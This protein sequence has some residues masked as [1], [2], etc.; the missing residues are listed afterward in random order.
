MGWKRSAASRR[1]S[2]KL[3][4]CVLASWAMEALEPRCLLAA[5]LVQ[6]INT[7]WTI[8]APSSL[9]EVGGQVYFTV[10]GRLWR[11]DGTESGTIQVSPSALSPSRLTAVGDRLFF[12]SGGRLW[13]SDGTAEGTIQL[14]PTVS[15]ISMLTN[16]NGTLFF[17]GSDEAG[18]EL[19]KSDGTV[20]G[21]V[22]VR[23]IV[24][25][26]GGSTPQ[27]L[28]NVNGILYFRAADAAGDWELWRSDGT[29]AGTF[30]VRD[31]N[32]G[33]SSFPSALA[34]VGNALFFVATD[35]V[36]GYELWKSDGTAGGTVLV[37]DINPGPAGSSAA[38]LTAVGNT[39]YFVATDGASG[40]E[41]WK[42][43]GTAGGTQMVK[44]IGFGAASAQVSQ[45]INVG[46]TLFFTASTAATGIELWTSDGTEA[47]TR[48]VKDINPGA[49]TSS[50][51]SLT[52]VGTTLFFTANDGTAGRELW[53]SDGTAGGT[54]LVK[55]LSP[56]AGSSSPDAL[57]AA[58]GMLLFVANDGSGSRLYRSDGTAGGTVAVRQFTGGAAGSSPASLTEV[59]GTLFFTA[60]DGIHGRELWKTDGT[61]TAMV[62]DIAAGAASSYPSYLTDVNGRLFF[63]AGGRLWTSDGTAAGTVEV[64]AGP[65][66]M[67]DP[68]AVGGTLYFRGRDSRG[69]ELWKSDGTAGGTGLVRDIVAGGDGIGPQHLVSAGGKLYFAADDGVHGWELWTSDGT[70]AGTVM[71]KDIVPGGGSSGPFELTAVGRALFFRATDGVNGY[72]LWKSDG[73]AA[74]TVLV[75]DIRPGAAGSELR[76]LTAAGGLL[77]F[78]ADDGV[79]GQELWKSDG[80]EAGTVLVK[81]IIAGAV[82][83]CPY[84]L[85]DIDGTV[86]FGA[87]DGVHGSELWKSDGTAGGTVLVKDIRPGAGGSGASMMRNINGKLLFMGTTNPWGGQV[88]QSDGTAAGTFMLTWMYPA[89]PTPAGG[90][91]Y[92]SASDGLIGQ[93]LW[94]V[95]PVAG[96]GAAQ[97]P[98]SPSP[99]PPP[100][101][102]APPEAA[103]PN[104]D[105]RVF[106]GTSMRDKPDTRGYGAERITGSG[107]AMW[108][109]VY[110]YPETYTPNESAV[111]AY[112]V[113]MADTGQP[114]Y[115]DIEHWPVD[116]RWASEGA[117]AAAVEKLVRIVNWMH[118][119]RPELQV[120]Y[121]DLVPLYS[122]NFGDPKW[123]AANSRLAPLA[124]AVDVISPSLYTNYADPAGWLTWARSALGE[125]AKYNKPVRPFLWMRYSAGGAWQTVTGDY[126]RTML[127]TVRDLGDDAIIWDYGSIWDEQAQWWAVT[128]DFLA[129]PDRTVP[130]APD[131]LVAIAA[132][133]TRVE[134]AWRD[135]SN[136]ESEF[137]IER[138]ADGQSFAPLATVSAGV[139]AY[140]D[141]TATA[142]QTYHY[143]ILSANRA[144]ASAW[145]AVAMATTPTSPTSSI[146]G[147]WRLDEIAGL[148]AADSSGRGHDGLLAG[149]GAWTGGTLGN[150]V[151]LSGGG[152]VMIADSADFRFAQDDGF[153]LSA[154][155]YLPALP[156]AQTTIVGRSDYAIAIDGAGRWVFAGG[157][158][159]A[160]TAAQVGWTHVAIVQDGAHGARRLYVNGVL[161]ATGAA[162]AA[163]GA[164]TLAFGDGQFSGRID[165]VRLYGTALT[166]SHI[167]ALADPHLVLTGSD[168]DDVWT[169]LFDGYDL[170]VYPVAQATGLPLLVRPAD[171]IGSITVTGGAGDDRLIVDLLGGDELPRYGVR[172]D[173]GDGVDGLSI[174]G[175]GAA[176]AMTL[177]AGRIDRG[178]ARIDWTAEA[179]HLAAGVF[180]VDQDLGGISLTTAAG[181]LVQ[182]HAAQRLASIALN[183]GSAAM[184][185]NFELRTGAVSINTALYGGRLD[186]GTGTLRIEHGALP[187]P[188]L[189]VVDYLRGGLAGGTWGGQGLVSSAMPA[190]GPYGLGYRQLDG[191]VVVQRALLGDVNQDGRVNFADLLPLS[192]NY[193][194]AGTTWAGGDFNYDRIVNFADLLKLAQNYNQS[195]PSDLL[196]AP[197]A[198]S[199]EAPVH[200]APADEQDESPP[201][202]DEAAPTAF[203]AWA[204]MDSPWFASEPSSSPHQRIGELLLDDAE[205][206]I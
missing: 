168:Q 33:G 37:K 21:T 147:H 56:G 199:T 191:A 81:D 44:D 51:S 103:V 83:S 23:D 162:Q 143:R 201:V 100:A 28:V 122:V 54:V 200:L 178:Q 186:I 123:E 113:Q 88:W 116:I 111:R 95:S 43:D 166:A 46:G 22:R 38:T 36:H 140:S 99:S 2:A 204:W 125:A 128:R 174:V 5:E 24:P 70:E 82:G 189:T 80:T 109:G 89:E 93:E 40:Y 158:D 25:G 187:S 137:R 77:Y 11:T 160:G 74:G 58:G 105:Y 190:G 72:E 164:G 27:A 192:Q 206:I 195:L 149:D 96:T 171:A 30:R 183:G 55:D 14:S 47:G 92:F 45:L 17:A 101:S 115:L 131:E 197:P 59:N 20:W 98:Q 198:A 142:G 141:V 118:D 203:D 52:A 53:R 165:D 61:T 170:R 48:L 65:A 159:V 138:S 107:F 76:N 180:V 39:L 41:L 12:E 205:A 153:T 69:W 117:V 91:L 172:F 34:A 177:G 127:D 63:W 15:S 62:K 136:N 49:A 169:L 60:D 132:S 124:Q 185:G 106:D 42:S 67:S 78:S 71:V 4:G 182:F 97:A 18:A 9:V 108:H 173:G 175:A 102:D 146:L 1:T 79:H 133:P 112:A 73:T 87:D 8:A 68:V 6:D 145:S 179:L 114:V 152:R 134:L 139:T 130:A 13:T 176:D 94:K 75:K 155:V 148:V 129:A 161:S 3:A 85:I 32:P 16:V 163:D 50:I 29:E 167:A 84:S 86:F 120:G 104:V 135:N 10:S 126:W 110:A 35:G 202:A 184:L 193:G 194:L 26:P 156:T 19:W 66:A 181:A 196:P 119:E 121:Y 157:V 7:T 144:G 188:L 151:A 57:A 64:G 90:N 150:A 154:W 31:I